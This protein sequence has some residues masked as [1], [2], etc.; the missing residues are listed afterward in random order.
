MVHLPRISLVEFTSQSLE[1]HQSVRCV[2][3]GCLNM[4]CLPGEYLAIEKW[5]PSGNDSH[6]YWRWWFIVEIPIEHGDFP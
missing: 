1:T 5:V 4:G 3:R 6:S 2:N